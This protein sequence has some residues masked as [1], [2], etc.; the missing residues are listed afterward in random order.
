MTI[1][2]RLF[3]AGETIRL[4]RFCLFHPADDFT[5]RELKQRLRIRSAT[6]SKTLR[7]LSSVG[8]LTTIARTEGGQTSYRIDPNWLLFTEF[9]ALFMKA[10]LLIEHDLVRRLQRTGRLRLL[11]LAGLFV[12]ERHGATDL[13]IVGQI[14][15]AQ[16]TRLLKRFERDLNEEVK[17]TIMSATEYCYRK[18]VGDRFLYDVLER[19]HLVVI[20]SLERRRR[21]LSSTV[22]A[23]STHRSSRRQC[24]L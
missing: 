9:R 17:Y 5:P 24:R 23:L 20:D 19:R 22:R 7:E 21:G 3:G 14:N 12:G 15:R 10:Q 4:L 8:C 11:I 6:I 13:L 16:A 1:V 18:D 2:E